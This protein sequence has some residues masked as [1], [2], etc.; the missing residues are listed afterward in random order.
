MV[1]VFIH[2]EDD[3]IVGYMDFDFTCVGCSALVGFPTYSFVCH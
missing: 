1:D 3:L 2:P